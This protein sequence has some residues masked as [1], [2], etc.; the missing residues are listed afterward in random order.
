[1]FSVF[2]A[3]T[4]SQCDS[5]ACILGMTESHNDT[6]RYQNNIFVYFVSLSLCD[7]FGFAVGN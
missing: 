6:L 7:C 2:V 5:I 3:I 4:V 1:M